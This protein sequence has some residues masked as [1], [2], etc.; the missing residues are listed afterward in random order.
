MKPNFVLIAIDTLR[1]SSLSCYGYPR[2]TSPFIDSLAESG[3]IFSNFFAPAVP[4]HPGFT[5]ILSGVHPVRSGVV[6]HMGRQTYPDELPWL[7]SIL[8]ENGYYTMAIDNLNKWFSRGFNEY[9]DSGKSA[10]GIADIVGEDVN[11]LVDEHS[12]KLSEARNA[13]KPFFLFL[14]YWDPHAPYAP[15]EPFKSM[16]YD[17]TNNNPL[18]RTIRKIEVMSPIWFIHKGWMSG[19]TDEE[20]ITAMYDSEISY[21]DTAIGNAVKKLK[22]SGLMENTILLITSD[23]GE[24]MTEHDVYFDHHSL[25]EQVIHVPLIISGSGFKKKFDKIES[26]SQH[27]DIA[28]TVLDLAGIQVPESIDG[29]SLARGKPPQRQII[30]VE[31]TWQSKIAIRT[32]RYKLIRTVK[33]FDLYGKPDGFEE[34]YDLLKDPDEKVNISHENN[35]LHQY[36]SELDRELAKLLGSRKNPVLEQEYSL[37]GHFDP[38]KDFVNIG[39]NKLKKNV[40]EWKV[41]SPQELKK[42]KI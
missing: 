20:Y 26:L 24:S 19:I 1:A 10:T 9:I 42:F 4:T 13:G 18:N 29:I 12:N 11:N 16:F 37:R 31:N 36:S 39:G 27:I 25:Y 3:T 30:S 5:S 6:C 7:P 28:P 22:L 34:L 8:S 15:P 35:L 17:G 41:P 14:H 2:K 23:H 33:D 21:V 38:N 32:E 40:C